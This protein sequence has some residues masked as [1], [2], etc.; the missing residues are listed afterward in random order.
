MR[1]Y[2]LEEFLM[3]YGVPGMKRPRGLKYKTRGVR[4]VYANRLSQMRK[5]SGTESSEEKAR[6]LFEDNRKKATEA[7][8]N[9]LKN[10]LS[11][12]RVAKTMSNKSKSSKSKDTFLNRATNEQIA[13][14]GRAKQQAVLDKTRHTWHKHKIISDVNNRIGESDNTHKKQ[15]KK[16]NNWNRYVRK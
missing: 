16:F 13:K 6:R 14:L 10:K 8:M 3:H 4:N 1:D 15:N 5:R 7:Y 11:V 9:N 2:E 12:D